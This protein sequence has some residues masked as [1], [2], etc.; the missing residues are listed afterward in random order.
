MALLC[1]L[2]LTT[3]STTEFRRVYAALPMRLRNRRCPPTFLIMAG[4]TREFAMIGI[5]GNL[6]VKT[7][8]PITAWVAAGLV[9]LFSTLVQLTASGGV[10]P[11]EQAHASVIDLLGFLRTAVSG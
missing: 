3:E 9:T 5:K 7:R 8:L 11:A 4:D 10:A 1:R 6:P 2:A